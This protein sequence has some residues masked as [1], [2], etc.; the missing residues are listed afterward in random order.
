MRLVRP[1]SGA[2][3]APEPAPPD[4]VA[5]VRGAGRPAASVCITRLGPDD[6]HKPSEL[7]PGWAP[8][9]P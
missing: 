3:P 7:G 5:Q 4:A 8:L 2:G 9:A 1:Q 6:G